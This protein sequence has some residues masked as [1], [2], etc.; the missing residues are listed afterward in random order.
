MA[1]SGKCGFP[2][3]AMSPK[4]TSTRAA[5]DQWAGA[6][7]SLSHSTRTH[8]DHEQ[9]SSWTG[10]TAPAVARWHRERHQAPPPP[11][12]PRGRAEAR[13]GRGGGCGGRRGRRRRTRCCSASPPSSPSSSTAF[14]SPAPGGKL[15]D[16]PQ[17]PYPSYDHTATPFAS[18]R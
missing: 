9:K 8:A 5:K 1:L 3:R 18:P 15:V 11:P 14:S 16:R 10:G 17:P 4:L 12:P 2:D 7:A 6:P 13:R